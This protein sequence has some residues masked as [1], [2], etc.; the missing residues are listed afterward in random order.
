M[1]LPPRM[2]AYVAATT[3]TPPPPWAPAAPTPA[4]ISARAAKVVTFLDMGGHEKYLKT[5]LYG[6]TALLPD[7]VLLA[8]CTSAGLGRIG[9]EHLAVAVA[10]EVP[11]AVV[12]TKVRAGGQAGRPRGPP[13]A[14]AA[15]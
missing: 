10:L 13:A 9:V 5:A 12:L 1:H 11:V 3:P 4:E 7:Y 8:A 15:T 14:A 2:R 6:L